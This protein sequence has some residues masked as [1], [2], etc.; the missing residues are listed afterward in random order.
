MQTTTAR[1]EAQILQLLN[2]PVALH[3][4]V[5]KKQKKKVHLRPSSRNSSKMN[6]QVSRPA[7]RQVS[8]PGSSQMST[9][10]MK[11]SIKKPAVPKLPD[12]GVM[13]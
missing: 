11:K 9:P 10:A 1:E 12:K 2:V 5:K 8:R 3:M 4:Q 7:S 13:R 6:L